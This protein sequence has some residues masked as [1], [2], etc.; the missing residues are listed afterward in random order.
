MALVAISTLLAVF[1]FTGFRLARREGACLLACYGGYLA[2][3]VS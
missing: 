1:A 3:L 2:L